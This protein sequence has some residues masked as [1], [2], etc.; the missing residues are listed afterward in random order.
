MKRRFLVVML[1]TIVMSVGAQSDKMSLWLQ[2]TLRQQQ[3]TSRRAASDERLITT[4]VRTADEHAADTLQKHGCHIYAQLGDIFIVTVPLNQLPLLSQHPTV[5]RIEANPSAHTTL[6]SVAKVVDILPAY[7]VTA[8]HQAFT[9]RDVIVGV[10]DVGFDLT[11]PT[12]FNDTSL[13]RYRI[14]SFWDQLAPATD[15]S[16]YPV[17]RSY[18]NADDILAL[19]CA[20]D[21]RTQN[22]G[23][24]T[25]GIAVGSGYDSPYRGVAF[26][27]D[28]CLVANAVTSDTIYIPKENYYKYTSATDALGFKYLFDFAQ[29]E[30]KPCVISFSEGYTPYM[31]EDDELFSD[32]LDRL[33]GPGRILVVSAGN[34]SLN[35]TYFEKP[36]GVE[37]A[38][39]FIQVYKT[40]AQ[41]R[42]LS[43]GEP[44][45]HLLVYHDKTVT[46]EL[47]LSMKSDGWIDNTL[48]DT[49]IVYQDTCAITVNRYTSSL[50]NGQTM[51]QVQFRAKRY[52]NELGDIALVLESVDCNASLYGSASYLLNNLDTDTRWNA[53]RKGRNVL[54]PGCLS[55]PI[56]VGSTSYRM[57]YVNMHGDIIPNTTGGVV[58]QWSTFS[59][60]GP[61][62]GGLLKPDVLAPGKNVISSL[63]SYYLEAHPE[64]TSSHIAH[65][66]CNGRT[67][68][69]AANG[70]T[71]MS[72]PVVAGAIALWLQANPLL[73]R[74]DIIGILER[75]CRHPEE[76]LSYPN[77][78]YGYGEVDVYRGLLDV[79][80]ITG[81][82]TISQHQPQ[83]VRIQLQDGMLRLLFDQLPTVPVTL[84]LYTTAGALLQQTPLT[85][86]Q[87][88]TTIALPALGSGI[89]VVQLKGDASVTGSQLI[90]VE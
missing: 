12:F 11:H 16:Q 57:E 24:H 7:Q 68:P 52:L 51:Y 59:S 15:V 85:I 33:I 28:L 64:E 41:Y 56:C 29:Q 43:D 78:Q 26:E 4:F 8:Q 31:D 19:G 86:T 2:Q 87:P 88:V 13:S 69:W 67:Y 14:R 40:S 82:P 38:G 60:F 90:R 84:S 47:A 71:S 83:R 20:T 27:S 3:H 72:T 74:A 65:F 9:G 36:Q 89:Y 77:D 42:L 80:G 30:G 46:Q 61:S 62:L 25:T 45:L 22:H 70:G 53:A 10:M 76:Q 37:S 23:T 18:T 32:F 50:L 79:L 35:T 66:Q 5:L 17:G 81:I 75:T 73:T 55:A 39:S 54:A 58:G 1:L 34:E 63:S 21:G 49:L 6:D 44:T 48:K